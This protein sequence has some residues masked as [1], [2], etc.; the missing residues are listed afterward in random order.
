MIIYRKSKE[1]KKEKAVIDAGINAFGDFYK[2]S[3]R[4]PAKKRI[5]SLSQSL[6]KSTGLAVKK[7]NSYMNGNH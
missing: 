7:V 1:F 5:V 4:L 3:S 6:L 2:S